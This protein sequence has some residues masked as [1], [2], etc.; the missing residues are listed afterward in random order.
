MKTTAT[1]WNEYACDGQKYPLALLSVGAYWEVNLV[2]WI[3]LTVLKDKEYF[4][5]Y[6]SWCTMSVTF[7]N[8]MS[9]IL[10]FLFLA[11]LL[12]R[13]S[14]AQNIFGKWYDSLKYVT[15]L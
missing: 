14:R 4:I 5:R 9:P 1:A 10:P 3:P 6:T 2:Q 11:I 13:L 8:G 12:K 15:S 7:N